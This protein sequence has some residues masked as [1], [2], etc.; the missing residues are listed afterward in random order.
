MFAGGPPRRTTTQFG[1]HSAITRAVIRNVECRAGAG[2]EG[3]LPRNPGGVH[4]RTPEGS[5]EGGSWSRSFRGISDQIRRGL[6]RGLGA[7]EESKNRRRGFRRVHP[8]C[9]SDARVSPRWARASSRW[10]SRAL[11]PASLGREGPC[12]GRFAHAYLALGRSSRVV[13]Q[14][15]ALHTRDLAP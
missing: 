15:A 3:A 12:G 1:G 9:S 11:A 4:V 8:P 2:L 10:R 14:D 13:F 5:C 6:R 7:S